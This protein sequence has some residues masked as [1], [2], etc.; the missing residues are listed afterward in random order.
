VLVESDIAAGDLA[1]ARVHAERAAALAPGTGMAG[2]RAAAGRALAL[3]ALAEGDAARAAALALVAAEDAIAAGAALEAARDRLLAGRALLDTDRD[4]ALALLAEAGE[5]AAR[6]GAPR[7]EA[8]ARQALR[9]AGV[10]VG[11]GG[12]RA[13]GTG[14]IDALSARELEIAAL[15]ADGLTNREIAARL[16]LSEKTVESHLTRVFQKLGVRSRAQVAAAVARPG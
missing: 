16:F 8:E 11:S 7:V 1:A 12:A 2:P 6:C 15:V 9:Q 4:A 10:R 13:P 14:G 5:Q 3:V